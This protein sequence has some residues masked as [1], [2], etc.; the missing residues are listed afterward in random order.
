[1]YTCHTEEWD[2]PGRMRIQRRE[3]VPHKIL[4]NT[5]LLKKS[6]GEDKLLLEPIPAFKQRSYTPW[7]EVWDLHCLFSSQVLKM[8]YKHVQPMLEVIEE[9]KRED[10]EWAK[11]FEVHPREA[12]GTVSGLLQRRRLL[13]TLS[14]IP[15]LLPLAQAPGEPGE[16]R[17]L[18]EGSVEGH[19]PSARWT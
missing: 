5:N 8:R 15:V 18:L 11:A 16:D 19:P 12:G 7:S 9:K 3:G 4:R 13:P 10:L 14:P 2:C 17:C 1:M 6:K